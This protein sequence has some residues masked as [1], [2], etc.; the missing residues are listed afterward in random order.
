MHICYLTCLRY[1]IRSRA[2]TNRSFYQRLPFMRAQH[3]L[4]YYLRNISTL[5]ITVPGNGHY[6]HL[7]TITQGHTHSS[8]P[9]KLLWRAFTVVMTLFMPRFRGHADAKIARFAH[10]S[11]A[12]L[13]LGENAAKINLCYL[14]CLRHLFRSRAVTRHMFFARKKPVFPP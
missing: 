14:S 6:N 3:V 10:F 11:S 13:F 4:S 7:I 9:L 8:I 2:D 12:A 5:A 1:L